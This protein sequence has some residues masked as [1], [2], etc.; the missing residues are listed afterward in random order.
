MIMT[1]CDHLKLLTVAITLGLCSSFVSAQT[2]APTTID[3][4]T[5]KRYAVEHNYSVNALRRAV[6]EEAARRDA[7]DAAFLPR[8]GVA[9]GGETVSE[10]GDTQTG[11][12]A[13]GYLNYNLFAGFRDRHKSAI[14]DVAFE[15][16]RINLKVEEYKVGLEV[17]EYFHI[18]LYKKA[19][20]EIKARDLKRNDEHRQLVKRSRATGSASETDVM[21]F[22][23]KDAN[24]QSELVALKQELEDAR[25]N[26]KRLLGE[27][28]GS[29]IEPVGGLQHQHVLGDLMTYLSRIEKTS[30]DVLIGVQDVAVAALE[31]RVIDSRW[32]PEIDLEAQTGFLPGRTGETDVKPQVALTLLAK[33]ELYSGGEVRAAGREKTAAR[34][35]AEASLKDAINRAIRRVEIGYRNLKV[36][37]ARADLERNNVDFS[38]K[39]YKSV[40]EEYK[41]GYKNSA[42]L[43]SAADRLTDSEAR[44]VELDFNFLRQKIDLEKDLGAPL[45]VEI[46]SDPS[47]KKAAKA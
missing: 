29:G 7:S 21:E 40:T 32:L 25:S 44:R 5:A 1:K 31:Q 46:I 34:A 3:L 14:A 43:S 11:R 22:Q 9:G 2:V 38:T 30:S 6:E 42:D 20:I 8:L 28:V 13:Y 35:R 18:Y 41:R 24:I 39:Y 45:D 37:E 27:D 33:M 47:V 16:A 26:L 17:E 19:Q 23:I 36:I 4:T 15:K 10:G 12:V